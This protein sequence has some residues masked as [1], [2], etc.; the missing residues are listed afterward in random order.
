MAPWGMRSRSAKCVQPG[1]EPADRFW[2]VVLPSLIPRRRW[3]NIF[4]IMAGTLLAWHRRL[5]ARK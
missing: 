1:Y 3:S 4:P 5:I 2:L